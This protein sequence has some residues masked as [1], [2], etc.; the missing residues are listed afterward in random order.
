MKRREFIGSVGLAAISAGVSAGIPKRVWAQTTVK[1][2]KGMKV[3]YE[4]KQLNLRHT[5]TISRNSSDFKQNVFVTVEKDG[6]RGIGEAAPNV[7]YGETPESTVEVIQKAIPLFAEADPNEYVQLGYNIQGLTTGQTAAKAALDIALMDWIGKAL[8]VP[9]Y[10][11]WGLD[12]IR[13]M[14]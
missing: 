7:R 14:S 9:L 11:L 3:S 2:G 8:K 13:Q 10:Q 12:P 4:I 5:W 6:I 1:K